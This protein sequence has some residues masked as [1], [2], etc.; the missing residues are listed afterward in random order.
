MLPTYSGNTNT[1]TLAKECMGK[2]A[3]LAKVIGIPELEVLI[4]GIDDLLVAINSGRM[5]NVEAFQQKCDFL[6]DYFHGCPKLS[7]N[8]MSPSGRKCH[9]YTSVIMEKAHN[10]L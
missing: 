7:W 3:L 8:V 6:L 10:Y 9:H 1:G 5:I 2:A 4:Q